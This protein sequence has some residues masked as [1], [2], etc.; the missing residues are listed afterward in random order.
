MTSPRAA[1]AVA[2]V[3]ILAGAIFVAEGWSKITGEFVRG[4]FAGSVR[5]T[6]SSGSWP[7]WAAFLHSVVLPNARAFAWFFAA[8][9]LALGIALVLGL[10]TRAAAVGGILLM[11]ILLLGQTNVGRA[12]WT[13]W[14]TAGLPGKFALL[15]LGMLFL[16]DAGKVWGL[17]ARVRRRARPFRARS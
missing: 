12:S 1:R 10:L 9:E 7:F 5:E 4:G 11:L 15:L 3:R 6:A 16:A 17:D 14:V 13:R 2:I 8:A